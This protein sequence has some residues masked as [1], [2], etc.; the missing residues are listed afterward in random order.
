MYYRLECPFKR[1]RLHYRGRG[2][3]PRSSCLP[4]A[5]SLIRPLIQRVEKGAPIG[6]R[7]SVTPEE[8]V[9]LQVRA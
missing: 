4:Q 6:N 1:K 3:I 2:N 9:Y 5:A 8:S 7:C